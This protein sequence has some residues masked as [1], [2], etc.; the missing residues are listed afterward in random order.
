MQ[1]KMYCLIQLVL[2]GGVVVGWIMGI[3]RGGWSGTALHDP[4]G[5]NRTV[6]ECD[7]TV[8]F[9]NTSPGEPVTF[10]DINRDSYI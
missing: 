10:N 2:L 6:M 1:I 4:M 9:G 3:L 7:P 5:V 8:K